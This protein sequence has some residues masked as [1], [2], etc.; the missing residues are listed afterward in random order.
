MTASHAIRYHQVGP[1]GVLQWELLPVPRPGPT[2]VLIRHTAIGVNMKEVGE[3]QGAYP[4][5]P[6]PAVPGIEAVGI[7]EETG[8]EVRHLH[9]GQRV[10]YATMPTG[11][12]C[13]YRVL[14][15]DRAVPAPDGL[16]DDVIAAVLHKGMTVRYLVRK[17]YPVRR[18]DTILVHAAAGGTGLLLCQWAKA[19][20][21]TVIGTVGSE[22]KA[23]AARAAGCDFPIVYTRE[24]FLPRVMEITSGA[25]V[26]VV[27]DSVGADTFTRSV[28]CLLPLGTMVLYGIA[29]G[30]PP[31]LELM[32]QDIWRSCFFTRPSFFAHTRTREDL[33]ASAYDLFAM[34]A[35]GALTPTIHSRY[36][37][38]DA[39]IAHAVMESR[40]TIGSVILIP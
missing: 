38:R 5:P 4:S 11:S 17:T 31:P 26:P 21:A 37:L 19:L 18:G 23:V 36:P 25:G 2:D 32:K 30:H 20:G 28:D 22:E 14:P 29:S 8:A 34:L 15:A 6:L 9:R 33:L 16:P 1:P 7:V 13:E 10:C 27:Y 35:S 40:R 24:D 12:Y 3:R 39:A